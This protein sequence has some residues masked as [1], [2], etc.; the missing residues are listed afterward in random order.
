MADPQQPVKVTNMAMNGQALKTEEVIKPVT[1]LP[2]PGDVVRLSPVAVENEAPDTTI[3]YTDLA[4]VNAELVKLK[5][6]F[7]LV[8]K[9]LKA[10]QRAETRFFWAYESAKKRNLIQITGGTEKTR[11]GAAELLA[12]T[13]YGQYL[14]ARQV[15][16]EV[17]NLHRDLKSELDLLKEL[18]NN[19]RRLIDLS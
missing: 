6:K 10:A 16:K 4:S 14:V 5:T 1:Q 2:V 19:L 13:E 18:S 9:D 15:A 7:F 8:R 17:A 12:E 3:D 11:E